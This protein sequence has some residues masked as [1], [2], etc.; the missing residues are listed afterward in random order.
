MIP[1]Y[2]PDFRRFVKSDQFK[3]SFEHPVL[4]WED[5]ISIMFY[6]PAGSFIYS[7]IIIKD[8]KPEDMDINALKTE[9]NAVELPSPLNSGTILNL[10]GTLT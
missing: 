8:N 1:L 4:Y 5:D 10:S 9:F 3:G 7:T 6:K 2:Y